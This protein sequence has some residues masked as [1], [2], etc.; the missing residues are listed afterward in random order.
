MI[1]KGQKR[2][3]EL[4]AQC[5]EAKEIVKIL[6][7]ELASSQV[8]RILKEN[9]FATG[10]DF[11]VVEDPNGIFTPGQKFSRKAVGSTLYYSN[12]PTD[13]VFHDRRTGHEY[14]VSHFSHN[15]KVWRQRLENGACMLQPI[16]TGGGMELIKEERRGDS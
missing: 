14:T 4:Y 13:L 5:M 16:D 6:D 3:L 15:G 1:R 9:G 12:W 8:Y 10:L 11:S 2:V 7:G